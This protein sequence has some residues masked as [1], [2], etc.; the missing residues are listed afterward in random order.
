MSRSI[1]S[2][3]GFIPSLLGLILLAE[4]ALTR[5]AMTADLN[6]VYVLGHPI[7]IVCA[8]KQ[9]FGIPCPT[10]GFTRGFVLSIH[11]NFLDAW[12]LSPSGP[13]F[14]IAVVAAALVCFVYALLQSRNLTDRM[15]A[16]RKYVQAATFVYSTAGIA[17]WLATWV[18]VVR[19]MKL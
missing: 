12:R 8:A 7:N 9:H 1:A 17:I 5:F 3:S 14:A 19:G 2:R 6:L 4:L 18:T 10:C 11:G 15:Q 16:F 13:L